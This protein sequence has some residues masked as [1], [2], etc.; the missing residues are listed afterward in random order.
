MHQDT[1]WKRDCLISISLLYF[2]L[3]IYNSIF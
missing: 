2:T 1:K 3:F